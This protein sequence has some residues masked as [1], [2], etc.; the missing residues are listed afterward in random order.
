MYFARVLLGFSYPEISRAF[1]RRD[2]TTA[3]EACK[4]LERDCTK[5]ERL[6]REIEDLLSR[7]QGNNL[8]VSQMGTSIHFPEKVWERLKAVR[9]SEMFGKDMDEVVIR[10][11]SIKLYEL[12]HGTTEVRNDLHAASGDDEPAQYV[13]PPSSRLRHHEP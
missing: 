10:L 13:Q 4:K 9:A 7:V 12:E 1:G 8:Y 3:M 2:H 5:D 11:V 6:N